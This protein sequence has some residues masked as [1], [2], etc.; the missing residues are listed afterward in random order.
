[1]RCARASIDGD[2]PRH[3]GQKGAFVVEALPSAIAIKLQESLLNRVLSVVRIKQNCISHTEDK[4][5]LA[6]DERRELRVFERAQ[7]LI[8]PSG[9]EAETMSRAQTV[10]APSLPVHTLR[11]KAGVRCSGLLR[12]GDQC[13]RHEL[14]TGQ[15]A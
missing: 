9:L 1:M 11:R 15:D 14:G 7:D 8:A 2:S 3:P 12:W 6:L 10:A 4:T 13:H 5:R